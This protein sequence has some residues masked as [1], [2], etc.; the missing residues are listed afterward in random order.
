[1]QGSTQ[2]A[3]HVPDIPGRHAALAPSRQLLP[4]FNLAAMGRR[5]QYTTVYITAIRHSLPKAPTV[6]RSKESFTRCLQDVP[7]KC[8]PAAQA[9]GTA[10]RAVVTVIL[11]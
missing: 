2:H 5:H 3:T 10:R 1:M 7:A 11:V 4:A 9:A 6:S 8:A